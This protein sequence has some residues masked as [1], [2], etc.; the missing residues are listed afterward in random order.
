MDPYAGLGRIA[1]GVGLA[2]RAL[3]A[4]EGPMPPAPVTETPAPTTLEA[5]YAKS[6]VSIDGVLDDPVW[7]DAPAYPLT[8][9]ND[10]LAQDDA[11]AGEAVAAPPDASAGA[12]L[13]LD[14]EILG[15]AGGARLAD[16]QAPVTRQ[17]GVRERGEVRLAWDE[18]SLYIAVRFEDSD[19]VAT[20]DADQLHHYQLGDV[21][22]VFIRP[23]GQPGYWELYATP[24]GRKTSFWHAEP[25]PGRSAADCVVRDCGLRVAACCQGTLNRRQDRD[26]SWTAEMAIPFATLLPGAEAGAAPPPCRILVAR[27]N[28]GVT[29]PWTELSMAPGLSKTDFHLC[30]EYAILDLAR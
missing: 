12:D 16:P 24:H 17:R 27:Y 28:Y 18:T 14:D 26:T 25:K 11:A 22:E 6:A 29:L 10:R 30:G 5:R 8:L 9:G 1:F 4:G 23:D 13:L 2:F 15:L 21:L 19:T 7:A 3:L 20:G